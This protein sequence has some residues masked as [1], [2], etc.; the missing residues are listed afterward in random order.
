ML[1]LDRL[2]SIRQSND[3]EF[4]DP[5]FPEQYAFIHDDSPLGAALCTRRAGKSYGVGEKMYRIC[6]KYP[7]C[8]VL[9]LALTKD[10]ARNIMW[11]DV[12]KDI[13]LKKGIVIKANEA[14]L[15][16]TLRNGSVIKLAGADA[17]VK[18]R[19]K[20]LGGKY[21]Y[22]CV[23][24]AGSFSTDLKLL[25]EEYLEPAVSDYDGSVDLI[26]TP[27]I[28]WQSFFCDVTEGKVPGWN[29]HK[30]TT[31]DN[32]FMIHWPKRLKKLK[33]DNP[34]VEET[35]TYKR[36]YLGQWVRDL[37][38]LI[39]KYDVAINKV[40]ALP[41]GEIAGQVLGIDLGFNDH[42][43]Y[44]LSRYYEN[45]STLYFIHSFKATEQRI[46]QIVQ[47]IKDYI[48]DYDI[49]TIVIDNASKQL[50]ESI[51]ERFELYDLNIIAA[52]KTDKFEFIGF[53]NSDLIMGKIKILDIETKD[54][55]EEW[56]NLIRDPREMKPKEHPK[57]DNHCCDSA[58]YNWRHARNYMERPLEK[59]MDEEDEIEME[60]E[61]EMERQLQKEHA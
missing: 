30:W 45:D 32:P 14:K 29:V 42:T 3:I 47:T 11:K 57:C 17:S 59:E 37:S 43:A 23:D 22:V 24:E 61:M 20:F 28:F 41:D 48:K 4:G 56:C 18:E 52:E 16:I 49:H 46:N 15:E 8:T 19:E 27:T 44:V 40:F 55:E 2:E 60:I 5:D 39:Y 13:A 36:M 34:R 33:K 6:F 25:V 21:A 38:S 9:Y 12:L 53:M 50:V 35:P 54:L 31:L 7:G 51:K 1:I 26:G 10:S 58:L